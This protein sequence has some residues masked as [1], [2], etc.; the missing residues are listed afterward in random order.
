M[1]D[2]VVLLVTV[3]P[4]EADAVARALVE[5]RLAA[6]VTTLPAIRSLYWWKGE[7]C[8]D[9]G[10]TLLVKTTRK[11]IDAVETAIRGASNEEVFEMLSLDV[12]GGSQPYIEWLAQETRKT[13]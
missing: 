7:L 13:S 12:T 11:L 1:S 5:P 6:C 2:A 9:S 4:H 8:D 10:A 3:P